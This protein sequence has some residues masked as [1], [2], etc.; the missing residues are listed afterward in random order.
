MKKIQI[1]ENLIRR[2]IK[3]EIDL[4]SSIA[5]KIFKKFGNRYGSLWATTEEQD[6][7]VGLIYSALLDSGFRSKREPNMR[8]YD[9][10]LIKG[11]ERVW[12][13][14]RTGS[15]GYSAISLVNPPPPVREPSNKPKPEFGKSNLGLLQQTFWSDINSSGLS[16]WTAD[17]W[18]KSAESRGTFD[19]V[20]AANDGV[21]IRM[22][23]LWPAR[24]HQIMKMFIKKGKIEL[25][26]VGSKNVYRKIV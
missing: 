9:S 6:E 17:Q 24:F 15:P 2:L 19:Q 14:A 8:S 7:K 26:K 16:E 10:Y 22:K 3:E 1:V 11:D 23:E 21:G 4:G 20:D 18:R 5:Y 25:N 12:Y 13:S